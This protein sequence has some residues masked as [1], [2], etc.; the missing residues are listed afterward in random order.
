MRPTFLIAVAL[1]EHFDG[2]GAA[3]V[4]ERV[5]RAVGQGGVHRAQDH[6]AELALTKLRPELEVR[7][8]KLPLSIRLQEEVLALQLVLDVAQVDAVLELAARG[9]C[10]ALP[11]LDGDFGHDRL[12]L[13]LDQHHLR[14]VVHVPV[15][16]IDQTDIVT[17]LSL[18]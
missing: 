11:L 6:P 18:R 1:L 8:V 5:L 12:L 4:D 16:H 13:P 17:Y 15:G 7:A 9:G 2:D 3:D 10:E 14:P